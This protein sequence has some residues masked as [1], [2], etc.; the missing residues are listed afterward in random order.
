MT[1]RPAERRDA[2]GIAS[3]YR[4]FCEENIISFETAAPDGEEIAARME[5]IGRR[6]PWL[7]AEEAGRLAGYAYASPHRERAA[8]RWVVEVTVYVHPDFHRRGVAR[9]LY[10]EL[11]AR[12][13]RQGYFKAYAG[14]T[15]PNPPSQAFHEALGFRLVG[16]YRGVGYKMGAWRD[17]GWWELE[18]QPPAASPAEPLPPLP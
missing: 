17:V 15:I 18:L 4:P 3:I 8:Y 10:G 5:R 6:H 2:S 11:F 16:I 9:A 1:I 7:V 12:L 13:R 14:I